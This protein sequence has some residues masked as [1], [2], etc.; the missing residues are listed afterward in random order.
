MSAKTKKRINALILILAVGF[1]FPIWAQ[2]NSSQQ[3]T[4]QQDQATITKDSS[5]GEDSA[6]ADKTSEEKKAADEKKAKEEA[7]KAKAAES[8]SEPDNH[9]ADIDSEINVWGVHVNKDS[10]KAEEY[11]QVPQGFLL[12]WLRTYLDMKNGRYLDLKA[13]NVGLNDGQ[14]GFDYGVYGNYKLYIDYNKIPHLFSKDGVIIYNESAPGQ[15]RLPDSVQQANQNLN[16]VPTT[17]PS[18][19]TGLTN[20]RNFISSLIADAHPQSLDL[21]RNRG[22]T[23][24]EY[25]FNTNWKANFEYFQENRDGFRPI[26]T[27][28]SFSNVIEFPEPIDYH[29]YRTGGGVEYANNGTVVSAGYQYLKFVNETQAMI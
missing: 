10:S 17:D 20:Q 3:P 18:Y 5:A 13:A 23:G 27:A 1:A 22:T 21:Q 24:F 15:W 12:Q 6:K 11:G 29:T 14:Y 7:E 19:Q 26:G 16:N 25:D 9:G 8:E 4:A 28:L 2:E